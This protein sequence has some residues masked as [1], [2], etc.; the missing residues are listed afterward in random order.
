MERVKQNSDR[1]TYESSKYTREAHSLGDVWR[2]CEEVHVWMQLPHVH[3]TLGIAV[4]DESDDG[5]GLG[6]LNEL[7]HIIDP[8]F[9]AYEDEDVMM[10]HGQNRQ[11]PNLDRLLPLDNVDET[12]VH[13]PV[14]HMHACMGPGEQ[15]VNS[16]KI[17]DNRRRTH[18]EVQWVQIN[19]R[20]GCVRCQDVHQPT[21][22][23][24]VKSLRQQLR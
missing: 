9:R 18:R 20:R 14:L 10:R 16:S 13:W 24:Q 11:A 8:V 4:V 22:N 6:P 19:S 1:Q 3:D 5:L 23:F 7:T 17:N 15:D 21:D 12:K 2:E